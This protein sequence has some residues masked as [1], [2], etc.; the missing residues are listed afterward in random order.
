VNET[1][2]PHCVGLLST[3]PT[4]ECVECGAPQ[5]RECFAEAGRCAIAA[6][7][8]ERATL[9]NLDPAAQQAGLDAKA[10]RRFL[11]WAR[12]GARVALLVLLPV[13][14]FM[15]RA[16]FGTPW[17]DVLTWTAGVAGWPV[18][19]GFLLWRRG[20]AP[21]VAGVAGLALAL[22]A[23]G[24]AAQ[25]APE[26]SAMLGIGWFLA[27]VVGWGWVP[28]RPTQATT[29]LWRPVGVVLVVGLL[30]TPVA[31]YRLASSTGF[32]WIVCLVPWPTCALSVALALTRNHVPAS[33]CLALPALA[34]ALLLAWAS[35]T[36]LTYLAGIACL[37][38]IVTGGAYVFR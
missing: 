28:Q 30:L 1:T 6:C 12:R 2:C 25:G 38:A 7:G 33:I 18:A 9:A 16:Y 13:V 8:G 17:A 20:S 3:A 21:W 32:Q 35:L 37:A 34:V 24:L 10:E 4:T 11:T 26:L 5:H 29:A 22:P 15:G 27:H 23:L 31:A 19:V 36:A 14:A